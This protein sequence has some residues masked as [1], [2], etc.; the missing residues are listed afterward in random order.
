MVISF[1]R[2]VD[3]SLKYSDPNKPEKLYFFDLMSHDTD[4]VS[5][6]AIHFMKA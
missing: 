5:W 3:G 6:T 2:F 1:V 4:S